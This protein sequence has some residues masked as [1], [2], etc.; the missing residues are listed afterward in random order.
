MVDKTDSD[1]DGPRNNNNN[2]HHGEHVD[3][4]R[5]GVCRRRVK[6]TPRVKMSGTVDLSVRKKNRRLLTEMLSEEISQKLL[7]EPQVAGGL[8]CNSGALPLE[9]DHT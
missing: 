8:L 5:E 4:Y 3:N 2:K 1:R 6:T 7:R 9:D